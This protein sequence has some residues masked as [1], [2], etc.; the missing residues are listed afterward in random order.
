MENSVDYITDEENKIHPPFFKK[1]VHLWGKL[2]FYSAIKCSTKVQCCRSRV[3]TLMTHD[4][5]HSTTHES[6]SD[7]T[8]CDATKTER[9]LGEVF[10]SLLHRYILFSQSIPLNILYNY[11]S[12]HPPH[13]CCSHRNRLQPSRGMDNPGC[14]CSFCQPK[15]EAGIRAK[16]N[17]VFVLDNWP[18]QRRSVIASSQRPSLY[19]I[20]LKSW[21]YKNSVCLRAFRWLPVAF[22]FRI[23]IKVPAF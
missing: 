10:I 9:V 19:L 11:Q 3:P 12:Q 6:V 16:T 4:T 22:V 15:I 1:N 18:F 21:I 20:V 17:L 13:C 14:S 8:S 2:P 23:K 7:L 5:T